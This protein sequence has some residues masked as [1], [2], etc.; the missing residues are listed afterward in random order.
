M[1]ATKMAGRGIV[2]RR[3]G[4]AV[5]LV[6]AYVTPELARGV[7]VRAAQ[8]GRTR[9]ELVADALAAHLDRPETPD[10]GAE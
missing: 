8:E 4:P 2:E 9:S 5:A 3:R 6:R 1:Q 7:A 10:K